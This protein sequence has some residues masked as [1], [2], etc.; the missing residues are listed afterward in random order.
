MTENQVQSDDDQNDNRPDE[1]VIL[2]FLDQVKWALGKLSGESEPEGMAND[3]LAA[4]L[5]GY[6]QQSPVLT[7]PPV[8]TAESALLQLESL[9]PVLWAALQCVA[10]PRKSKL[11]SDPSHSS[12]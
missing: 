8:E 1:G 6:F 3:K 12:T 2:N 11:K 10:S 9:E 7:G 4:Y 5:D